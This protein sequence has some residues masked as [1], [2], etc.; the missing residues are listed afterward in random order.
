MNVPSKIIEA[1]RQSDSIDDLAKALS[2]IESTFQ[3][4]TIQCKATVTTKL[5]DTYLSRDKVSTAERD[6]AVVLSVI[7]PD[8]QASCFTEHYTISHSMFI[9]TKDK[10]DLVS[11]VLL[12]IEHWENNIE[13]LVITNTEAGTRDY[14]PIEIRYD[15]QQLTGARVL[16]P[17]IAKRYASSGVPVNSLKARISCPHGSL[18]EVTNTFRSLIKKNRNIFRRIFPFFN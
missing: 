13:T 14:M 5:K 11:D 6:M 17:A 7:L 9:C 1:I 16:L 10:L 8:N 15:G 18:I 2:G 4:L 3:R 12:Q